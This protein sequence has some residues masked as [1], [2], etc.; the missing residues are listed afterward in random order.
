MRHLFGTLMLLASSAL[1]GTT[2][3]KL[4]IDTDKNA[5][6]GCRVVTSGGN[7]DGCE[8]IV[9]TTFDNTTMTVTGVTAQQCLDPATASFSSPTSIDAGGW[10]VGT[11]GGNQT[12]ETHVPAAQVGGLHSMR[13]GFV[14]SSGMLTDALLQQPNGSPILFLPAVQRPGRPHVVSPPG[15]RLITLDGDA[16][17]WEG[18]APL[19]NGSSSGTPA[20][21]FQ[22]IR[23]TDT[24][25]DFFFLIGIQANRDAPTARDDSYSVQRG[26]TLN[27]GPPGVLANDTD[28]NGKPLTA[29]QLSGPQHGVLSLNA[30]GGFS[31]SND[32]SVAPVDGFNYKANNGTDDSNAAH[33]TLTI[34]SGTPPAITS[35][36]TATFTVGTFGSFTVTATG[37]PTPTLSESGPLPTG[38]N[39]NAAT[40]VLSGTPAVGTG[41]AYSITF[42]AANSAGTAFQSFTLNVNEGP[43]ITTAAANQ[44]VC[45]GATATFSAA[46]SGFPA[47]TVQWQLSTNGGV[48]FTNIVGA[49]AGT[50]SFVANAADNTVTII[51]I[52][53]GGAGGIVQKTV[54]TGAEPWNIVIAP[55]GNRV[56]VA[57]RLSKTVSVIDT[58]ALQVIATVQMGDHPAPQ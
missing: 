1:A 49:T 16:S 48:T 54:V 35:P 23:A 36:P 15:G 28:P 44:T 42:S 31:Y 2:D 43:A 6:T 58:A 22:S 55:N 40:G 14:V 39:F 56:Y 21:R 8:L 19:V 52:T 38:V 37:N 9:T 7:F 25:N 20:L 47:P 57:N 27:V 12:L 11:S 17:E 26:G 3:V 45:A 53:G 4:L 13:L 46:A 51:Q 50:Y 33:V 41:G 30:N 5:S 34:L 10:R 29:I 24:V 32:G 18:I